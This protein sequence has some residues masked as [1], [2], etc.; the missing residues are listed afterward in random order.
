MPTLGGIVVIRNAFELDY[1][2]KECIESLLPVCDVVSVSDGESTDGTQ[3]FLREW[4]A[5]E[6]KISLNVYP[7]PN[8]KGVPDFF[9]TWLNYASGH[10]PGDHW[11]QLDAD[12]ILDDRSYHLILQM[13]KR[14]DRFSLW[15]NRINYWRDP[16]HIV[17]HGVCLAHR[18]VRYFPRGVWVPS[19]GIDERGAE[20]VNMA[21][22]SEITIHHVGFLRKRDAFFR[23]ARALQGMF[24]NDYDPR[25]AEAEKE[26]SRWMERPGITGWENECPEY[27][28]YYPPLVEEWLL[29]RGWMV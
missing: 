22:D 17:P 24:F 16:Q 5:K 21:Q 15:C 3:E 19:D 9:T 12:E 1:C 27:K 14:T 2:V 13:K 28:G 8:P 4:A 29:N 26:D 10:T 23:K 7:W 6:P 11:L 18:V 25:L 20:A